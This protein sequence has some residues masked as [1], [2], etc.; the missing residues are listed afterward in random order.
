[1]FIYST[2]PRNFL[3]FLAAVIMR[4]VQ[5]MRCKLE[6]TGIFGEDAHLVIGTA[7]TVFFYVHKASGMKSNMMEE[8]WDSYIIKLSS[9]LWTWQRLDPSFR[10]V[11]T[12]SKTSS[13]L[14]C[15]LILSTQSSQ[16]FFLSHV[17]I[18]EQID[19]LM[20]RRVRA[21]LIGC[22]LAVLWQHLPISQD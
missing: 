16:E 17:I 18:S 20:W 5:P 3:S 10:A 2:T 4:L 11:N 12:M 13:T 6:N 19:D 21:D 15:S 22:N 7:A 1:M 8:S 9:Y 14:L